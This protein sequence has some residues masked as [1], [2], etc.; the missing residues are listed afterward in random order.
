MNSQVHEATLSSQKVNKLQIISFET[1]LRRY[2]LPSKFWPASFYP[3][4]V[5]GGGSLM[6]GATLARVH[7]CSLSVP[8]VPIDD[9]YVGMILSKLGIMPEHHGG[10][11][12]MRESRQRLRRGLTLFRDSIVVHGI[13]GQDL[14][15][16]WEVFHER[17]KTRF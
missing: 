13:C 1:F 5:S 6:S 16:L 15:S 10:F 4:Y 11:A 12:L 2:Y 3:P 8:L 14:R 9:V 17:S 7:R